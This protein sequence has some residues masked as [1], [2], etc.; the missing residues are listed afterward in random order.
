MR[1][2]GSAVFETTRFEVRMTQTA[3]EFLAF[4]VRVRR[5]GRGYESFRPVIRDEA[6]SVRHLHLGQRAGVERDIGTDDL[7]LR[8][9]V[10]REGINL[11]VAQTAWRVQ[12]S[13]GRTGGRAGAVS[14]E[15]S[16][17]KVAVI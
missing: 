11:V 13:A 1:G 6:I 3:R 9:D 12:M 14:M 5:L 16:D 7:R 17:G 4:L 15:Y 10:G 2:I 8:E